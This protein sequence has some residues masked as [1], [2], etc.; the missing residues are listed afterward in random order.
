MLKLVLED[1]QAEEPLDRKQ[2]EKVIAGVQW[3]N[4]LENYAHFGLLPSTE[5]RGLQHLED[6]ISNIVD[7]LVKTEALDCNPLEGSTNTLYYD[8]VLREMMA[9][10][11]HPGKKL[12][13]LD[14]VGLGAAALGEVRG[15][16]EL[17]QLTDGQWET[18]IP[19]G[20][21]KAKPIAFA[22][23]TARLNVQSKRDLDT[24][25]KHLRSWPHYYL[26]V[27]GHARAEGDLQA[28]MQLAGQRAA[29]AL[30]HLAA[31]GVS[32]NRLRA[33]SAPPSAEGGAAQ[34]VSFTVGQLPY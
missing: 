29:A 21:L 25:V 22:R 10:N 11:F 9:A 17:A 34:S 33:V 18:L 23:G 2:A 5:S 31:Q 8:Q 14:D 16:T 19:V 13:L 30:D 6:M 3:K 12:N 32:R 26:S 15:E 7:V 27:K 28:N 20:R 4:T 1:A 24:L